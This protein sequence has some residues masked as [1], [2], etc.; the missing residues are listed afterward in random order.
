[1]AGKWQRYAEQNG[2]WVGEFFNR[3]IREVLRRG[4]H[5]L[6]LQTHQDSG[7]AAAHW[8]L[9]PSGGGTR[10]GARAQMRFPNPDHG[11]TPVG[12]PG[13]G[14]ANSAQVVRHVVEREYSK[15]VQKAVQGRR[16]ATHFAFRS[17]VPER[18]DDQEKDEV[19]DGGNYRE[20]ARLD[21][22]SDIALAA[23]RQRFHHLMA[24]GVIRKIPLR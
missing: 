20:N 3:N 8:M 13:D 5:V 14:G 6:T 19:G 22:A 10:P 21:E 16:P 24:R 4:L 12:Q 7:R 2:L 23:M 11:Q 17:S 9:I 18:W 1:M 15:V